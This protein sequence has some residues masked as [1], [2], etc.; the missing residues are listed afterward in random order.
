M[1]LALAGQYSLPAAARAELTLAAAEKRALSADPAI[2]ARESRAQALQDQAV[3]DGQLPD[4][5]LLLGVWNVPLDDFSLEKEPSS[6]VRA[7][8]SQAFPRG[9]SLKYRRGHT[10]WLGHAERD[11]MR[12]ARAEIRRDVREAYLEL[13]FQEQAADIIARSR[14]LFEQLVDITRAHYASGRVSQ[15]DVLQAQLELS[16]L[17]ER[18][19]NIDALRDV[20]RAALSRWIGNAAGQPLATRFPALPTLPTLEALTAGLEEH[21]AVSA[22]SARVQAS[23]ARVREARE[24]YKPGFNIGVEYRK[25]FGDNADGSDRPDQMAAM[26]T[27]DLPVFTDKRQDKQLSAT[28]LRSEAAIQLREQQLRELQRTLAGDYAR[29]KKLGEQQQLY[30]DHLLREAGDNATSAVHAYQS[31]TTEFSA[32]MRA[33]ITELDIRLQDI[34]IRV[35]RAKARA[36]LLYMSPEAGTTAQSLQGELP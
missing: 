33:R 32:L 9:D 4:P 23:Q 30:H 35:D 1:A 8:I 24:Q 25:R 11:A 17:D 16:R 29:W 36:R 22:A 13:Y 18:A 3:A 34:R 27:L 28:Q 31:G 20:Q 6:Q 15:Q 2:I 5:K 19:T 10:E 14:R 21:P 26:I 12:N 7:G